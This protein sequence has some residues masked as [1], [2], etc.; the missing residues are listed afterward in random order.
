MHVTGHM[1]TF[2]L[3]LSHETSLQDYPNNRPTS[4]LPLLCV[5]EEEGRDVWRAFHWF[6]ERHLFPG[7]L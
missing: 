4:L 5:A 3:I 2:N 7:S 6:K 1:A